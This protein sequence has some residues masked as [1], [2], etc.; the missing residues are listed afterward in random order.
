MFVFP[1][2][3]SCS[4]SRSRAEEAQFFKE[5][6]QTYQMIRTEQELWEGT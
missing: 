6:F 4:S 2:E 3:L 5:T 1:A